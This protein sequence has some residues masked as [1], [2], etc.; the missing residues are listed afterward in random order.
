M[1]A[2]ADTSPINYLLLI[3]CETLLPVLYTRVVIPAAVWHEL[4][5]PD[6]PPVVQAWVAHPPAWFAIQRL[7]QGLAA[8][9]MPDLGDGERE[10]IV[11]AQ[12]LPADIV[13][14]D[15][16]DGR[17]EAQGRGLIVTGTLGVLERAAIRGLIDLPRALARLQ[18]T[19]FR[20]RAEL[21]Q[22]LLARD[23]ARKSRLHN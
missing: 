18:A 19:T 1:L 5:D 6:T 7:R 13:L 9:E 3:Q 12:E 2:V 20:A 10:A 17:R 8:R 15:E 14:M 11:L 23:A 4:Q 22:D 16:G 21:Y